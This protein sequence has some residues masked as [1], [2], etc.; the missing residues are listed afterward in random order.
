MHSQQKQNKIIRFQPKK[1]SFNLSL[2]ENLPAD[3]KILVLEYLD[4]ANDLLAC[5]LTSKTFYQVTNYDSFWK[6]LSKHL[7]IGMEVINQDAFLTYQ[8]FHVPIAQLVAEK[9]RI[10]KKSAEK[11]QWFSKNASN[12]KKITEE[13]IDVKIVSLLVQAEK[14]GCGFFV[15]NFC[16]K[17][18]NLLTDLSVEAQDALLIEIRKN[19]NLIILAAEIFKTYI[20]YTKNYDMCWGS[21]DV[22]T[23]WRQHYISSFVSGIIHLHRVSNCKENHVTKVFL[24]DIA[25]EKISIAVIRQFSDQE[26]LDLIDITGKIAEREHSWQINN[27]S[28]EEKQLIMYEL[29]HHHDYIKCNLVKVIKGLIDTGNLDTFEF[30]FTSENYNKNYLS[31]EDIN[32]LICYSIKSGMRAF[33]HYLI[34]YQHQIDFDIV[35]EDNTSLL[36]VAVLKKDKNLVQLLLSSGADVNCISKKHGKVQEVVA[37]LRFQDPN[38]CDIKEI[39]ELINDA[40]DK[41]KKDKD[42]A[43]TDM[44]LQQIL[45]ETKK[46]NELQVQIANLTSMVER[47]MNKVD[48]LE[49][50]KTQQEKKNL[51]LPHTNRDSSTQTDLKPKRS[52]SNDDVKLFKK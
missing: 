7:A 43:A 3:V 28:D 27:F 34:K 18:P 11:K 20:H 36:H 35:D 47:L 40:I 52:Y 44:L 2:I 19:N 22:Q 9:N 23:L 39:Q 21:V 25:Q 41:V 6:L 31:S 15:R 1:D 37:R 29:F 10:A 38:N 5:I 30:F 32:E 45:S 13:D 51:P 17:N 12:K 4:N 8:N 48:V 33:I 24:R 46:N 50:A 16:E 14:E 49:Q 26:V 42:H